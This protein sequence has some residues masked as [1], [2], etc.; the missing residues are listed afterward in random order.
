[1]TI[2]AGENAP[3]GAAIETAELEQVPLGISEAL[4]SQFHR[5]KNLFRSAGVSTPVELPDP[6]EEDDAILWNIS[7]RP[8]A[9][10]KAGGGNVWFIFPAVR[11]DLDIT[12]EGVTENEGVAALIMTQAPLAT[13]IDPNMV[14]ELSRIY[15]SDEDES[16]AYYN[17]PDLGDYLFSDAEIIERYE[18][19]L[20]AVEQDMQGING[21]G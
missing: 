12:D 7:I 15:I 6:C 17:S 18:V 16:G 20:R 8:I 4:G 5:I 11:S 19:I 14:V 13:A 2:D 9:S 10:V 21:V 1:M 3:I